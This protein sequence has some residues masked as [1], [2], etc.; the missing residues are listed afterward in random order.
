MPIYDDVNRQLK[1]A[2][3]AQ[4]KVRHAGLRGIRAGLIDDMKKYAANKT[5]SDEAALAVL[6]RHQKQRN[7]SNEA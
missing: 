1:E 5:V 3:K 4:D 6:R 2:M 7:D